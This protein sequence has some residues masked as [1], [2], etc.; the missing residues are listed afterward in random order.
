VVCKGRR[1]IDETRTGGV[2]EGNEKISSG[3]AKVGK[4][5]CGQV[6]GENKKKQGTGKQGEKKKLTK[7]FSL[8]ELIGNP[9]GNWKTGQIREGTKERPKKKKRTIKQKLEKRKLLR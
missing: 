9:S 1:P 6:L 4:N 5:G 7:G 8:T 3:G 2:E